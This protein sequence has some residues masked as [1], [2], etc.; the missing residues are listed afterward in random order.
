MVLMMCVVRQL[1]YGGG[2]Y[3]ICL[4]DDAADDG[5]VIGCFINS[6]EISRLFSPLIGVAKRFLGESSGELLVA[7]LSIFLT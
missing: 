6:V 5:A 4:T 2:I 1:L 3:N 7:D